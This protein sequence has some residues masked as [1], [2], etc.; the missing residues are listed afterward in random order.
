ME[1]VKVRVRFDANAAMG[2]V[3]SRG[4]NKLKH[5]EVDV[6]RIQEQQPRRLLP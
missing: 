5:V 4:L 6:F 3:K 1:G 2:P